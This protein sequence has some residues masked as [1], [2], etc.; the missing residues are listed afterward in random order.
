MFTPKSA[1]TMSSRIIGLPVLYF[2]KPVFAFATG[3]TG[4]SRVILL[5]LSGT[6]GSTITVT[7]PVRLCL[8]ETT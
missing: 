1:N 5:S 4:F 6:L 2:A 7:Y 8:K 3:L